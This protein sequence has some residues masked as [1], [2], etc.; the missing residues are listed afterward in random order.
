MS[1]VEMNPIEE[2]LLREFSHFHESSNIDTKTP[3]SNLGL[4]SMDALQFVGNLKEVF[5]DLPLTIF[6]ECQSIHELSEYL[7]QNYPTE[8]K[9]FEAKHD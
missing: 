5:P 2:K 1:L 9:I 8:T 6:L 4:N 7:I 3:F